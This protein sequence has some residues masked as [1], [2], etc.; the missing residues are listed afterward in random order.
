MK[1]VDFKQLES[2]W[3][4]T[5]SR[6]HLRRKCNAGEFP[7]PIPVSDRRIAWLE[8]EIVTWLNGRAAKRAAR[9]SRDE[10]TPAALSATPE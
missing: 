2:K 5:Y 9:P 8:D 1:L 3:G 4:I 10:A 7:K 6:D